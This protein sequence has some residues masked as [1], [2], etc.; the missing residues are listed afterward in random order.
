[1]IMSKKLL[2]IIV[3][4][5]MIS[6][7]TF[8]QTNSKADSVYRLL[9]KI[10]DKQMNTWN[11]KGINRHRTNWTNAV[12]YTGF[13]EF[14]KIAQSAEYIEKMYAIGKEA[15]WKT[16][17]KRTFADDYCV[18]QLYAQLYP[19]YR[20]EN[21]IQDFKFLADSIAQLP[22]NESLEWKNNIHLREL[23]WCD[24]L[25][26]GPPA[27]AYL[28]TATNDRKYLNLADRLWWKTTAYLY[29]GS[30]R[31]FIRDSRY[32]NR[33][34]K[35]G[36]KVFWSRGNGWV[37]A[38]LV[39]ML[40]NMPVNYPGRKKYV[41]LYR[42]MIS[43]LVD[44]QHSDGTW[45]AALLDPEHFPNLETSGTGLIS[46]AIAWGINN[47]LIKSKD[48]YEPLNS[49]W[50]AMANAVH[51]DGTPGYVQEVEK[52][53]GH[54]QY[55]STEIYGVGAFLLAGTQIYLLEKKIE[56]STANK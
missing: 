17:A 8:A 23:A 48:Y 41:K 50:Q 55:N 11:E 7:L 34:E 9:K 51:P 31:L 44:I 2:L 20:Q 35:N 29:D 12:G 22:L 16:G 56:A 45:H 32:F 28:Y 1:M 21:I 47:G 5:L 14:N 42:E 6:Q 13:T 4:I 52:E 54:V 26:M 38:G 18:G 46:Y 53:P 3:L 36:E 43:R 33:R 24:A 10:A 27:F 19:I 39:R 15:D 49:A 25:F 40:E 30:A 37:I